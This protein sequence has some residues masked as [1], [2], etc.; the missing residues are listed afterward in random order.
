VRLA[1]CAPLGQPRR[2]CAAL[3]T[4]TLILAAIEQFFCLLADLYLGYILIGA[5][6][7]G[8]FPIPYEFPITSL[9]AAITVGLLFGVLVAILIARPAAKLE[10]MEA[11]RFE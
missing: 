6:I 11:L 9:L 1:C 2:R 3:Y 5:M 7:A 10:I 8:G 4:E